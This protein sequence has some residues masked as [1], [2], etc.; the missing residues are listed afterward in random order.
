MEFMEIGSMK[1]IGMD[2]RRE[3]MIYEHSSRGRVCEELATLDVI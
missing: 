1:T 3:R 2:K